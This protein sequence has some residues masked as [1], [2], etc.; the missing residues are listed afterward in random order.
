MRDIETV[1]GYLDS[2]LPLAP[3]GNH[4]TCYLKY[5]IYLQMLQYIVDYFY[6]HFAYIVICITRYIMQR[7]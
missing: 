5:T 2:K 4:Q 7:V 1:T 6:Y 3:A